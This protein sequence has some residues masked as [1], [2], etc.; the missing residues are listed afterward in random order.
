M[1]TSCTQKNFCLRGSMWSFDRDTLF[2]VSSCLCSFPSH[3]W[4]Q[5]EKGEIGLRGPPGLDG[6]KVG[7][8]DFSQI[9]LY[10]SLLNIG[11]CFVF[12]YD[13]V[14]LLRPASNFLRGHKLSGIIFFFCAYVSLCSFTVTSREDVALLGCQDRWAQRESRYTKYF[15]VFFHFEASVLT[16]FDI[17]FVGTYWSTRSEGHTRDARNACKLLNS[18]NSRLFIWSICQNSKCCVHLFIYLHVP[19]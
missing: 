18:C 1:N 8:I 14:I 19:L 9:F 2:T 4:H 12:I 17:C 6:K 16:T 5:G 7:Q 11:K 15:V 10:F 13:C 3:F